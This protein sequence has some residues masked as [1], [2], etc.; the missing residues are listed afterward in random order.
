[1]YHKKLCVIFPK[2]YAKAYIEQNTQNQCIQRPIMQK[3]RDEPF[4]CHY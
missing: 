1:M 3:E 4:I 2:R